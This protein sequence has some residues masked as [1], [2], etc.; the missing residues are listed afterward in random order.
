M[1]QRKHNLAAV[2]TAAAAF[3][4]L[5]PFFLEARPVKPAEAYRAAGRLLD[6]ENSRPDQRLTPGIFR[7]AGLE[8]LAHRGR[9]VGFL[10]RLVPSGFMILSDVTEVTPQVFVS[11]GTG[12]FDSLRSH[13]YLSMI[14]DRLDDDKVRLRYSD[15]SGDGALENGLNESADAVQVGRNEAAWTSLLSGS[16]PPKSASPVATGAAAE[17][18]PLLST[19]WDQDAPYWNYTPRVG[20]QATYTGC[21]ATAMA[22]VMYYWKHPDRGQGSHSY[23]WGGFM[24]GANFDH[25]YDWDGMLEDYDNGYTEGQADS[26]ARLMSDVGISIDMDYGVTGSGAYPND[27][28]ALAAFFK[29]SDGA[30]DVNRADV[31]G[32]EAYFNIIRGQLDDHQPVILAIYTPTSGHAVVADGYRTSPSNQVHVNMGWSGSADAYYS[33]SN[34]YGYG[35]AAWDYAVVDIHPPQFKLNI[36]ANAGGTTT[37]PP[38]SYPFDYGTSQVVRVTA[39][40]DP[41]YRFLGWT[42][43]A[44]GMDP[45]I[46]VPADKQKTVKAGFERI[47]YAPVNASGVRESNRSFSQ[48]EVINVLSFEG[49]PDNI[50]ILGYRIYR[51]DGGQ[52]AQI[53][54]L[55]GSA[56]AFQYLDRGVSP[57]GEAVYRVVAINFDYQEGEAAVIEIR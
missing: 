47:I 51:T 23:F 50:D 17:V 44:A 1:N 11:F 14:L 43:H 20:G 13:P 19:Q 25:P 37:P 36:K 30:H 52:Q 7:L 4:A 55:T 9:Q 34:I 33:L 46:A 42:G 28:N 57:D 39:V 53:A 16:T 6:V 27:N 35:Y 40:S 29:Y 3:L 21:S 26:V 31:P 8:P 41:H 18:L 22:Q 49:H 24:L 15:P 48:N 56:G 32:W 45:A 10:A 12:D 54:F 38:G 5:L 2:M